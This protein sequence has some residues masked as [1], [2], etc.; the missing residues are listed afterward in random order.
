MS[1]VHFEVSYQLGEYRQFALEHGGYI[2]RKPLGF[3][4]T[5]FL[6]VLA[7]PVF[8]LK[9]ARVGRCTFSID[10]AGIVRT[11]KAGELRIPW[12]EVTDVHR[13]TRGL[14]IEKVGGAVPIP[15]RCLT[16]Q[17]RVSLDALVNKWKAECHEDGG[18]V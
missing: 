10:L 8:L 9:A 6:S 12:G 18:D 2:A 7:A 14:L 11:S 13:Y 3:F 4:G 5:A 1:A 17:Q 16:P 15:N